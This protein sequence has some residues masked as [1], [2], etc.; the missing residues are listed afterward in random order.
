MKPSFFFLLLKS[1]FLTVAVPS[2]FSDA[3]I[4]VIPILSWIF[5]GEISHIPVFVKPG[6]SPQASINGKVGGFKDFF[7]W[8]SISYMGYFLSFDFHQPSFFRGVGSPHQPVFSII[9]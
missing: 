4:S 2:Q 5:Y 7:L 1:E 6:G 8:L 3:E 9:H